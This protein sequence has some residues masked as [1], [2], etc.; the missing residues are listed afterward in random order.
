MSKRTELEAKGYK[1]YENDEIEANACRA[2]QA[3]SIR[4]AVRGST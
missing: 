4:S 1:T 2:T 3:C